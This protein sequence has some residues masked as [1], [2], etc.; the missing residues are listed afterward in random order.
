MTEICKKFMLD[1]KERDNAI[2]CDGACDNKYHQK[3]WKINAAGVKAYNECQNL[4]MLC[5][6]CLKDPVNTLNETLKKILSYMCIIDERLNRQDRN[7][8]Q[9]NDALSKADENKGIEYE[10]IVKTCVNRQINEQE[11]NNDALNKADEVEKESDVKLV[12]E[13]NV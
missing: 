10:P 11:R 2:S 1:F 9:I 6:E 3:C 4:K 13:K 12:N 5:D 8:E 7:L